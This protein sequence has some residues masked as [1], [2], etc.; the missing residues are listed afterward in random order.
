M[1]HLISI[2]SNL[3]SGIKSSLSHNSL[4]ETN[5]QPGLK[6]NTEIYETMYIIGILSYCY[7]LIK[8]KLLSLV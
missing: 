3:W 2:K 1:A 8:C 6:S 7:L 4:D 5:E